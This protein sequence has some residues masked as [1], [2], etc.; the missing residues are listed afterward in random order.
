MDNAIRGQQLQ[1]KGLSF[2]MYYGKGIK[3]IQT[4]NSIKDTPKV[5]NGIYLTIYAMGKKRHGIDY[6]M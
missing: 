5:R 1:M 4:Y 6:K 2:Q 3:N